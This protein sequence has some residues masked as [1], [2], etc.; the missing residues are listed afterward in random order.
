MLQQRFPWCGEWETELKAL[1]R[2]YV[3]EKQRQCVLDYDDL[4]L[5]WWQMAQDPG[6]AAE[7]GARFSHVLVDEYQDTNRLQA[8]ILRR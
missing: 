2:A 1:F 4:L 8:G 3:A 7:L 6:L 5:Y